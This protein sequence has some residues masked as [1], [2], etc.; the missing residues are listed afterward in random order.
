MKT[1]CKTATLSIAVTLLILALTLPAAGLAGGY[2]AVGTWVR[3]AGGGFGGGGP[4]MMA[5]P[6]AEFGGSLY[7]GVASD[8]GAQ[9]RR[10]AGGAWTM[11][12]GAGFGDSNNAAI[13]SLKAFGSYLYAGTT[14]MNGCQVWR[15]NG[16]AWT[17]LVGQDPA[18]TPGTGPGFGSAANIAATCM[19]V[20]DTK[21][22]MGTV[23]IAYSLIPPSVF[24]QGAQIWSFDG[25][26]LTNEVNN[27]FGDTTNAGV[28]TL[29]EYAGELYAGTMRV[30]ISLALS[31][32]IDVTIEGAGCE[33]RK[34]GASSWDSIGTQGFG[35]TGNAALTM[36]EPYGGDLFLGTTNGGIT[37]NLL[38]DF[39]TGQLSIQGATGHSDG[40]CIY[41]FDGSLVTEKVSGG[42]GDSANVA[43]FASTS[44][45]VPG[46]DVL[47]TGVLG[48]RGTSMQDFY[49][50]GSL[51]AFNGTEWYRGAADGF[52]NPLNKV[53]GSLHNMGGQ[54]YAGTL[55]FEE[56]CEVWRGTPPPEPVPV[57][58]SMTPGNGK[59]GS[60][61]VIA[62][63]GFG[64]TQGTSQVIFA[65]GKEAQVLTWSDGSITCLVP[66]EAMSGDVVVQ[67]SRGTSNGYTFLVEGY[68]WFLAEGC[69]QGDFETFVLVQNPGGNDVSVNLTY[70]TSTGTVPG[71]QSYII[72]AGSRHTFKVN[73][74][75]TD[76]D[77][78][79]MVSASGGEIICE[80]AMYGNNR[81]WAHDSIGVTA[82]A[83]TWYLAEGCTQG[84]FETF[85]L[86]Q[87]PGSTDATV[88]LTYMTS[89][90]S[91]EGPQDY[92]IPAGT[93]H[94]FKV[95]D[96]VT[97]WDVSTMV[98]ASGGQVI[99]ERA[100]YGN[101]R[102]WA[103]DSIG[104]T[105]PGST[106]Y[107]A[108]GC[109]QGDFETFVLVQNP[110]STDA[111][112]DLTYMTST[113][114]VPGP[115]GYVIPAGTR[116][117]FKVNDSV[118][119]WDVSTMVTATGGQVI[120]ERAMYGNNRTWAHDSIGVT[121]PGST[122]YL[123][124]GCTGGDFETFVLVQNP[125]STDATVDL[126]F[127]TSTGS[128]PGPKGYVIPAGTRHT[129]KVNDSVTDWDVSTM[130]TAT[131]GQVICERAMY[132][133]NRTWA[134]DS[135]GYDP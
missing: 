107:L 29:K 20:H 35:R 66:E 19:E 62:G 22:Y 15:Y 130:V 71:P 80:R 75:V 105:A 4:N 131:G 99:C 33:L 122:W 56:G 108:E 72:P 97:D 34:Q 3:V 23:N 37:V 87:N 116:H 21:L 124:E 102:T 39:A 74:S 51:R 48:I 25:A 27:G 52:G 42:F 128:V 129:F 70:M 24:S 64:A 63:E 76:W 5:A 88:N 58:V 112:V 1:R 50:S 100:M 14:N 98:T 53:I 46:K 44:V 26:V 126:T 109:T 59:T 13:T 65:E 111:T 73:D 132:G 78:S 125:G 57:I 6:F 101:N 68:L 94:T 16:S 36:M 7:C 38:Y 30:N 119:D 127:M 40:C 104:V 92:V 81:Q 123:A 69:T 67:T 120:C 28:T 118:T 17:Q 61:V 41:G 91:Q 133:N 134:H 85:V 84:D 83:S 135:I 47:L 77:V 106:W 121:A 79:T 95:N 43:A 110:G 117:T 55:N 86:V 54:V 115:K 60:R 113:G 18:G 10:Y 8:A 114:S 45:T 11:I 31:S 32:T 82:P 9:V 103:H 49:T 96:S 89:Q 12:N 93:R 2:K 90:G